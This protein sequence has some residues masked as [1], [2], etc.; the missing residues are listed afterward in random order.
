M[1]NY[2][3]SSELS[4]VQTKNF[5]TRKSKGELFA[6]TRDSWEFNQF[7]VNQ[8]LFDLPKID[9]SEKHRKYSDKYWNYNNWT[10]YTGFTK[11]SQESTKYSFKHL[12]NFIHIK[13]INMYKKLSSSFRNINKIPFLQLGYNEHHLDKKKYIY[14]NGKLF[15]LPQ[16]ISNNYNQKEINFERRNILSDLL[17]NYFSDSIKNLLTELKIENNEIHHKYLNNISNIFFLLYPSDMLE[18]ANYFCEQSLI[19][20]RKFKINHYFTWD[21]GSTDIAIFYNF[22]ATH[23]NFKIWSF[24]HSTWGGYLGDVPN[25]AENS[26]AGSDYYITSGWV[27]KENHLSSWSTKAIALVSP[28]YSQIANQ[29]IISNQNNS[30]VLICTGEVMNYEVIPSACLHPDTLIHWSNFISELIHNLSLLNI[31]ILLKNYAPRVET[32]L[33]NSNIIDKWVNSSIQNNITLLSN[34][35]G[36]AISIFNICS[37]TVWDMP[38][39]GFFE[40]ILKG[41]PAF[42]YWD[43]SFISGQVEANDNINNLINLGIFNKNADSM[44]TNINNCINDPGWYHTLNRKNA[45]LVFIDKYVKISKNWDQDWSIFFNNIDNI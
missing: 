35:K 19:Q 41:I 2:I 25:I 21:T 44:S 23:L 34:Q 36:N 5:T 14:P 43:E 32:I 24:Q 8:I 22:A 39:S 17:R 1:L 18:N 20:F 27:H 16:I 10:Y 13:V 7:L 6:L 40:S 29:K 9:F 38:G 45:L 31:T 12:L 4:L 3:N 11:T 33:N 28:H 26:I 42:S 37:V 30:S 15:K